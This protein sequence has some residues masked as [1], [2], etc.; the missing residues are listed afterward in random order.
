MSEVNPGLSDRA[1]ALSRREEIPKIS[2]GIQQGFLFEEHYIL[3]C[4]KRSIILEEK[5]KSLLESERE[6]EE[7]SIFEMTVLSA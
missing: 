4:C 3:P 1:S 6:E 5:K 2:P 7:D